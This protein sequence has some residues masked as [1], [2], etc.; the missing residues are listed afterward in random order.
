MSIA[1]ASSAAVATVVLL[2]PA[3]VARRVLILFMKSGF[4]GGLVLGLTIPI[5]LATPEALVLTR[6]VYSSKVFTHVRHKTRIRSRHV[7]VLENACV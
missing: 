7:L 1:A 3:V 4:D 5:A 6:E 2:L